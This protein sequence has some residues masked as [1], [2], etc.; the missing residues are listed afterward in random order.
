MISINYR[1]PHP[2]YEQIKNALRK[3]IISGIIKKD[4]KL[5]SVRDIASELAINPNTIQRAYKDLETEGYIYSVAGKGSFAEDVSHLADKRKYEYLDKLKEVL[6]EVKDAGG[7]R[8][9]C[10]DVVNSFYEGNLNLER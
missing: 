3:D 6:Q 8:D 4:E 2:I 1:D 5:P 7:T 9:E 10:I